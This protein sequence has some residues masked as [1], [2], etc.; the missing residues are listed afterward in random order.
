MRFKFLLIFFICDSVEYYHEN[1]NLPVYGHPKHGY[2]CEEIVHILLNP[3]FEKDL[4]CTT[5]PVSVEHNVSFVIDLNSLSNPN[6]VRADDLGSWKCTGSRCLTFMVEIG[7]TDCR[8]VSVGGKQV[9]IRRQYHVHGTD[10]D[11]HR[12]IA[13]VENMEGMYFVYSNT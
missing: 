11:F 5:H 3:V 2:N 13:F 1:I 10:S 4:L 8:I 12:M 9:Q 7:P 6:D